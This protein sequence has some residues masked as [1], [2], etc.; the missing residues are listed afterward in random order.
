MSFP[1]HIQIILGDK[2]SLLFK[3]SAV[4]NK[5]SCWK[6]LGHTMHLKIW[7]GDRDVRA[8]KAKYHI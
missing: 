6:K 7:S 1:T 2:E 5:N 4:E 8:E 3:S